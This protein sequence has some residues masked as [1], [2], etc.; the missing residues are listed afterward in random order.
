MAT[1]K[2]NAS[3]VSALI[4]D[5]VSSRTAADRRGLHT[6]LRRAL[7]RADTDTS[8]VTAGWIPAGDEVQ[9][10][11]ASV[12][13]SLRY[14]LLLRLELH[15]VQLRFGIGWGEVTALDA[16]TQDGPAWWAARDAIDAVHA[17]GSSSATGTARTGYR[18]AENSE[19]PDEAAVNAALVCQDQVLGS[20][21]DRSIRIL[22]GLVHG[23]TQQDIAAA[24]GISPS[25]VSQRV[26]RD[27]LAAVL[28]AHELLGSL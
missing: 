14:A 10:V 1:M 8:P 5:L 25:A 2:Q 18:R 3:P 23:R 13:D 16:Q 17:L 6:S 21:D 19:G 27:G 28:H 4:G 24:E 12:G 9:A 22:G 26:I 11:H 15:P 7:V 20:C